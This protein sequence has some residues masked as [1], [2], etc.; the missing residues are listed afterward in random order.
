MS[1]TDYFIKFAYSALLMATHYFW[2]VVV[3]GLER[4]G[5][6]AHAPYAHVIVIGLC[7]LLSMQVLVKRIQSAFGI[8]LIASPIAWILTLFVSGLASI[9][10][11]P[12]YSGYHL[13]QF[14]M[15]I[16]RCIKGK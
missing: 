14:G 9:V 10:V 5:M 11:M 4:V 6:G 12:V 2:P 7:A 8:V 15:C 1:V 13:I 3:S 16:R